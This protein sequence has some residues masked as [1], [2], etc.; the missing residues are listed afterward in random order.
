MNQSLKNRPPHDPEATPAQAS[1]IRL[2]GFCQGGQV[3]YGPVTM[4]KRT[5]QVLNLASA[6]CR[7]F[8]EYLV[9]GRPVS[10][11]DLFVRGERGGWKALPK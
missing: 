2:L 3:V 10:H 7:I 4:D 1:Q 5:G 11:C 8:V 9:E 6:V